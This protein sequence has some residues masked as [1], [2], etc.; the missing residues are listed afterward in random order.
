MSRILIFLFFI[1]SYALCQIRYVDSLFANVTITRDIQYATSIY[2]PGKNITENLFGDLHEP[3]GDTEQRRAAIV[4]V[5]G[6]GFTGGDKIALDL[7]AEYYAKRGFVCFSINYRL[8][9]TADTQTEQI[10]GAYQSAA[11]TKAAV[12]FLK[13]NFAT[14]RIDTTKIFLFGSSAG[15]AAVATAAYNDTLVY[16]NSANSNNTERIIATSIVSGFFAPD[17]I[18]IHDGQAH[19]L[20]IHGK[21]D[22]TVP[23]IEGEKI[24]LRLRHVRQ[25][26]DVDSLYF[27]TLGHGLL[28][29]ATANPQLRQKTVNFFKKYI[30]GGQY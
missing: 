22:N 10:Q 14:Y 24:E 20:I 27:P 25:Y 23:F 1:P 17:T 4:L 8:M 2:N 12:R 30:W 6:G 29:D 9:N 13:K 7:E 21:Q 28:Q 11:D 26:T 3:T 15:A 18:L 19:G 5:H 16:Y